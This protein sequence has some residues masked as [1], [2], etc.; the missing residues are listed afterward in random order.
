MIKTRLIQ[1]LSDSARYIAFQVLWMWLS[2]AGQITLIWSFT[3]LLRSA[4]DG[5]MGSLQIL[6]AAVLIALGVALRTAGDRQASR[7]SYK[8]SV[9]VKRV[10]RDRIYGKALRLGLS[11]RETTP[12][13]EIVQMAGEGV[14]QL[15]VYFGKYLSQFFYALLAPLTLFFFFLPVCFPAALVLL[16][17]VPLIPAVIVLVQKIAKR[18]LSKYWD[19]YLSLGDSFL[20]NLQ[21]MT[22]LKIYMADKERQK[23]MD[24]ESE[25]F[26]QVTMKVL[27]MQLNSIIVMDVIAYAGAALGMLVALW[28]LTAGKID[29]SAAIMIIWL[30]AE[31]FIPMRRLGSYFH[32][33]M[34]GMAASDR[35]FA[36]LDLPEPEQKTGSIDPE[37]TDLVIQG[38][39]YTYPGASAEALRGAGIQCPRGSFVSIV[40]PSGCGK[41]TIARV[42]TGR[43]RDYSGR[44]RIGGSLLSDISEESIVRNITLAA[45]DSYLFKGT[46][47]EQL[48]LADPGA[49]QKHMW[50]VLRA[51][52]L[53]GFLLT[54]EGLQTRLTE[55]ASNLS[56]GQRQ[57]LVVARALLHDSPIYIFD[58]VTSNIDAESE[59]MIMKAIRRL[60]RT[61]TV[62]LISHRLANV[63][64]SDCIFMMEDGRVAERGTHAQL[65]HWGG[66]YAALYQSQIRLEQYTW[67]MESRRKIRDTAGSSQAEPQ[68]GELPEAAPQVI[69]LELSEEAAGL[70][71][72]D[73]RFTEEYQEFLE[74]SESPESRYEG[75]PE[76]YPE[77]YAEE[78]TENRSRKST[79]SRTGSRRGGLTI[80]KEMIGQIRPLLPVMIQAILFGTLGHLCAIFLTVLA[81]E[82]MIAVLGSFGFG[83]AYMGRVPLIGRL[84]W[85]AFAAVLLLTAVMRGVFHFLEQYRNHLIAFRILAVIRHKVFA[86]LR[87]LCPARLEG[88]DKGD[89]I[90]L[91]TSDIEQLEVFYAHTISPIAIAL[92]TSCVMVIFIGLQHP[93]AGMLALAAYLVVGAVIPLTLGRRSAGPGVEMRARFAGMNSLVLDSLRG[94]EETIRFGGGTARREKLADRSRRIAASGNRLNLLEAASYAVSDLAV[95]G[96]SA[97]MLTLMLCLYSQG[98]ADFLQTVTAVTAMM[99]SFGPVLALSALSS[100]LSQTLACGDRVLDLL[101]EEPETEEVIRGASPDFDGARVCDVTFSYRKESAEPV[102]SDYSLEIPRGRII[103]I[104]GPSGCGKSTLL[105]LLMRFWDPG[106]GRI[107]ISD[108]DI[109]EINTWS[110]RAMEAY[111]TQETCLFHTSVADNISLGSSYADRDQIMEAAR[112]ASVHDFIMSLPDGYDTM[113]G[114]LGST[115]SEGEKQRIGLARAFCHESAFLLLDEPT[116]A[117][118]ALNEGMILK[119]VRE[120][121][122]RSPGTIVLVSHRKSTL[123]IADTVIEMAG[124]ADT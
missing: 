86:A 121:Q 54:Q 75:S 12:T 79:G 90:A 117:V 83:V 116:S 77:E 91:I 24:Q 123:S 94:L 32:I 85:A 47:E 71:E 105:K 74:R 4:L 102:L 100:G 98:G 62:I 7:A 33:A 9:D 124:R 113:V 103:G 70:Q 119:A 115:L 112:A 6:R 15:E 21:G 72:P 68:D 3:G 59:E 76:E 2:L 48:L 44:I 106:R 26:R 87:R 14:E 93:L 13:S 10:L 51:V 8:A 118:D 56:G 42:L 82:K 27:Q 64:E 109:R 69:S 114:E 40:G 30:A 88:R 96:F 28:Q 111:V 49:D 43:I 20:E 41:S 50:D 61:R 23:S 60:A 5:S 11:Y 108:T 35:I 95:L 36:F 53:E 46:V 63:T 66:K 120:M 78:H 37:Q 73:S 122:D 1:L 80:M 18:I 81:A 99:G 34:N 110:L 107:L 89:M 84:S 29:F 58:E 101:A 57:R 55:G 17:C 45:S 65:M 22:T 97:A 92:L 25:H 52:N 38:L 39:R 104:H 31:F 16:L 67:D 19:I